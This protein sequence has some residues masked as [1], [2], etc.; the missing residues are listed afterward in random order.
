[1][2]HSD[3]L[4]RVLSYQQNLFVARIYAM[5]HCAVPQLDS[6][7]S[8]GL[9]PLIPR[10]ILFGNPEKDRPRISPDGKILAYLAPNN[11]VLNVCIRNIRQNGRYWVTSD[12]RGIRFF[13][14]QQDSEHILYLQD[15]D[16]DENYHL[17]QSSLRTGKTRDLTPVEGVALGFLASDPN[18]PHQIL[19][20][21]NI[22]D[23]R[24]HDVY[25]LDL[26]NGTIKLD[27]K[28]SGD[29]TGWWADNNLE[30][31]AARVTLP[32]GG[33]EI[34]VRD[35][36]QSHWQTFQH[37]SPEDAVGGI[38]GFTRDNRG[39]YLITSVGANAA[40]L[41]KVDLASGNY[42]VIAEDS[43]FDVGGIQMNPRSHTLEAVQ[44]IRARGEWM[45]TDNSLHADFEAIQ[46]LQDGEFC[47][48]SRD[49]IDKTW[50]VE[51]NVDDGPRRFY[52]YDRV[53][54][55]ATLLFTDRPALE[56]CKLAKM[57]PI[58]FQARDG[59]TLFG[60]LTLPVGLEP[61][62][63][64]LVLDVHGGPWIRDTWG[65]NNRVQW[66][67][68]RGY[69]VLQVNYRGSTGY[70]KAYLNSGNREW[71]GRMQTDLL[72][73]KAWTV[74]HGYVDPKKVCIWGG[75]YGGYAVLVGLAS[76]PDEF[77]CG[78]ESFGPSNLLTLLSD[79]PPYWQTRRALLFRRVGN[80]G[81]EPE[82]LTSRSPLFKAGQIKA[83]LL[84][85]QGANDV[86][87]KQSESD[88]IVAVMRK[89]A[90][91]AEYI[92]FPDEGHG[93]ARPE[94]NQ[95]FYA[96]AERFLAKYLGGRLEP[97]SDKESPD[98]FLR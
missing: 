77:V 41:V 48:V 88:E 57:L 24:F 71:G 18:W 92:V 50:I 22:L 85:A 94:N 33:T 58:S 87:V 49:K 64:P 35:D 67:A 47:I 78:V 40:R 46:R 30:V 59:M 84:V 89:N 54:R 27:T 21:L 17:H 6:P 5:N 39:I 19:V 91:P 4:L 15:I 76:T 23:R 9:P 51:Y 28:N 96:I 98:A 12:K 34:R 11:G 20:G 16:G 75:S 26:E 31:R 69:A 7:L 3:H 14:W 74:K 44:F 97:A 79:L 82:F 95:I 68:N 63:L 45:L 13:M 25:R 32:D 38:A 55:K 2:S 36:S 80:P 8:G 53:S 61:R 43:Q 93:F 83:P 65:L 10:E 1:M 81:L 73:G 62:N 72:D 56:K 37:W 42:T 60:Y 90:K 66:L 29:V 86:R 52:A 70:G